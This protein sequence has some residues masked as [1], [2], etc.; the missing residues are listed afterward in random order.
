MTRAQPSSQD[1]VLADTGGLSP[2]PPCSAT[3][4]GPDTRL[5]CQTQSHKGPGNEPWKAE[6]IHPSTQQL[7]LSKPVGRPPCRA[8]L[9]LRVCTLSSAWPGSWPALEPPSSLSSRFFPPWSPILESLVRTLS[10]QPWPESE[11]D[12]EARMADQH[13]SSV[14]PRHGPFQRSHWVTDSYK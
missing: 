10:V 5:C 11:R 14:R 4:A 1:T 7:H 13:L 6:R 2:T 12:T 8:L 9:S 3:E